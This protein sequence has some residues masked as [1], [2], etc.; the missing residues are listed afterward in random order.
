MEIIECWVDGSGPSKRAIK[1][2]EVRGVGGWAAVLFVVGNPFI[3]EISGAV[4]D[5]TSSRMEMTAVIKALQH[6]TKPS[7]FLIHADSAYVV[8]AIRQKWI[9]NWRRNGWINS[10][11]KPVANRDLWEQLVE[12]IARHESV[13][14]VK[15]KGHIG[16]KH[17]ERCDR[18]ADRAKRQYLDTTA[19][20]R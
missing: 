7:K 1:G 10:K 4:E 2:Q 12:E 11:G 5:T 15:V 17:N 18:L 9:P 6:I 16:I 19:K 13:A 14:F 3:D 8:N 20:V